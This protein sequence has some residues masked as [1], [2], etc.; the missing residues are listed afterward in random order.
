MHNMQQLDLTPLETHET[1]WQPSH[2][3]LTLN[4]TLDAMIVPSASGAARVDTAHLVVLDDFI[5]EEE[6]RELLD[7]ITEPGGRACRAV[8]SI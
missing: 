7:F 4:V 6:R 2:A 3:R 1:S 8:G 5:G